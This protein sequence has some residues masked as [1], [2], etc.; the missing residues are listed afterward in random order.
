MDN[1]WTCRRGKKEGG[2]EWQYYYFM[3]QN[4]SCE[5][6]S[7]SACQEISRLLWDLKVHY[8]AHNSSRMVPVM[9]QINRVQVIT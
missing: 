6:N 7:R 4:P 3:E 2:D 9:S 8:R 5:A 1:V